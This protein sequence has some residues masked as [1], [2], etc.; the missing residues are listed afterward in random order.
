MRNRNIRMIALDLDNTTLRSDKSLSS[1]TA[2]ALNR[3]TDA[4]VHVVIS[5]GRVFTALPDNI[6][7][8]PGIRYSINSNGAQIRRLEDQKV[9]YSD[10]LE[11]ESVAEIRTLLTGAGCPVE[12]FVDGV[13]YAD[14]SDLDDLRLHGSRTRN[15]EYVLWSRRPV[16]S[17]LEILDARPDKVE[18]IS[19]Q[20]EEEAPRHAFYEKLLQVPNVTVTSSVSLNLE[21]GGKTT[22]KAH[23]LTILMDR[24]GVRPEELMA[25][26]D[27]PNDRKMIELAGTGVV[28]ANGTEEM[29]KIADYVTAS[30]DED[31][32]AKAVE[33][34]VLG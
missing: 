3:A 22:S 13:A 25:C 26:G 7:S 20:F 34:F 5:T 10:C 33:R 12:V 2:D 19:M 8:L 14:E 16:S 18:N 21:V 17:V 31:G 32:V 27:S 11:P 9:L 4:G 23:A 24:L 1:R 6:L 30:N 29:K 15:V 28:V